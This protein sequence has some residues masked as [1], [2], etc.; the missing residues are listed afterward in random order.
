MVEGVEPSQTIHEDDHTI[1]FLNLAQAAKGHTLVVP[2]A[3]H[4]DLTDIPFDEAAHV[5]RATVEVGRRLTGAL[6]AEIRRFRSGP[7]RLS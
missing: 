2:R 1:A 6:G 7:R 5:M 3:H 4:R